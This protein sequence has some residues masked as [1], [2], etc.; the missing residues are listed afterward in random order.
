M[1]CNLDHNTDDWTKPTE[2]Y[3]SSL[4]GFGG[5]LGLLIVG[6]ILNIFFGVKYVIDVIPHLQQVNDLTALI[7][8]GL[9]ANILFAVL[10][11]VVILLLVFSRRI[12]F[13][14]F[15]IIQI[16]GSFIVNLILYTFLDSF[17]FTPSIYRFM[18]SILMS[19]IWL[20]YLQHSRRIKSTFLHPRPSLENNS[21]YLM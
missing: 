4:D 14:T 5:W 12:L 7:Y 8:F 16:I 10:L 6:R 15:F 1:E 20:S 17:G 11:P 3:D 21:D 2:G 19:I 18:I 13:K 9:A